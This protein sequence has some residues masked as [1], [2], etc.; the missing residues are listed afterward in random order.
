MLYDLYDL[1][2]L[3]LVAGWDPYNRDDLVAYISRVGSALYR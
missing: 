2:D 1:Y 3:A